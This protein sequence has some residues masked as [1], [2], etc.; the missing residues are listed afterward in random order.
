MA[1]ARA[2]WLHD[3][4][5]EGDPA[6]REMFRVTSTTV[7]GLS[8]KDAGWE[9]D[10]DHPRGATELIDGINRS[11]EMVDDRLRRWG[12]EDL[13][14]GF[15][16]PSR[17][18]TTTHTRQWIIW[19]LMEHDLHHGGEISLILRSHGIQGVDL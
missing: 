8:L 3:L 9:D 5:G 6:I 7:P 12:P 10:E 2:C 1:G 11:W 16:R 13:T 17:T 14:V 4:I 15:T 18:G 19:H